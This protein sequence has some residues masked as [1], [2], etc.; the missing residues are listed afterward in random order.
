MILSCLNIADVIK[1]ALVCELCFNLC[2]GIM[3]GL[4]KFVVRKGYFGLG[5]HEEPL[6]DSNLSLLFLITNGNLKNLDVSGS[7]V[8]LG[9]DQF[10]K[11]T[12]ELCLN[13][14]KLNCSRSVLNGNLKRSSH[15]PKHLLPKLETL[16]LGYCDWLRDNVLRHILISCP[17]L[18][19]LNIAGTLCVTGGFSLL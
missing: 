10:F 13:M 18:E 3:K 6:K 15:F 8:K 9:Y 11:L 16:S 19:K 7:T 5:H 17:S 2:L 12:A 1:T 14:V 4:R